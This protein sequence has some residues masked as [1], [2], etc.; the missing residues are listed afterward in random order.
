MTTPPTAV[1][2]SVA[3]VRQMPVIGG[4]SALAPIGVS[5][6]MSSIVRSSV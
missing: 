1:L 5:P 4:A 3:A 6:Y 2:P